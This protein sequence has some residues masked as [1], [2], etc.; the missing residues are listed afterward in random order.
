[1]ATSGSADR[2]LLD[3]CIWIDYFRKRSGIYEEVGQLIDS[4]RV[5]CSKLILAE[6]IQGAR[7]EKEIEVIKDLTRVFPAI[8]ES[9]D[10]WERAGTLS[11]QLRK[12]GK[13]IGLSDCYIATLA[14]Q[15]GV[16]VYTR[17]EHFAEI[18]SELG[19]A[20]LHPQP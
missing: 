6:L 5:C 13:S 15:N 16:S 10:S 4:G 9:P 7:S 1:M 11:F 18:E 19:V 2:V 17:D 8:E 20:L 12:S 14:M 3:T